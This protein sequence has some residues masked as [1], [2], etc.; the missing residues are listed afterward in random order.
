MERITTSGV[1]TVSY[2]K[3]GS[4]PPLVLVHGGFSDHI[5]NWQ[6]CKS[7]LE[8]RFTVHA[9]ARRGRGETTATQGHSVNDE[10]ADVVAVLRHIGER[11]F[12]LGH[13]YGAVCALNA[14]AQHPE[15]IRKLVLY[16]H[17]AGPTVTADDVR[18]LEKF[19]EREDWDGLVE[20]FMQILQVPPDEIA[21][22]KTTPFWAVWTVDAKASMNDLRALVH[23][24]F[25]AEEYRSLSMPVQLM[26]GSESPRELY[27]TDALAAVPPNVRVTTLE[28]TAH[29]G[30]TMVP[31]Q[32]VDAI[33][34]FLLGVTARTS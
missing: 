5:T 9:I 17:P 26:I 22:I 21:E 34:E 4:G 28:G 3:Y 2:A 27:A 1:A 8:D 25:R 16:E 12:L 30:V 20:A 32:F 19:A 33:S 29:E 11:A 6:E 14:A 31:D 18:S 13:S 7:L 24:K 10:V 23:H 15:G